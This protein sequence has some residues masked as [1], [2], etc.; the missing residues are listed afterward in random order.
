MILIVSHGAMTRGVTAHAQILLDQAMQMIE[1]AGA[2]PAVKELKVFS[3]PRSAR[4]RME[5]TLEGLGMEDLIV[6]SIHL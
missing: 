4:M 5:S 3:P 2:V 1:M 6:Q